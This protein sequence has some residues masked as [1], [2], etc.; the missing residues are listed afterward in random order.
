MRTKTID[1][2]NKEL[3]VFKAV[4]AGKTYTQIKEEFE[5]SSDFITAVKTKYNLKSA[6]KQGRKIKRDFSLNEEFDV[7]NPHTQE[8]L[9]KIMSSVALMKNK[10]EFVNSQ[11]SDLSILADAINP[12]S[13]KSK[14]EVI[15]EVS[16]IY[17]KMNKYVIGE[18][19]VK[20]LKLSNNTSEIGFHS[21]NFSKF[22]NK[23][24]EEV[25][26]QF[27][28]SFQK[29]IKLQVNY[30]KTDTLC[31]YFGK[32]M[33]DGSKVRES[34]SYK[35]Q[36]IMEDIINF[37]N[38][39]NEQI[40]LLNKF[41]KK[42]EVVVT[43]NDLL[44]DVNT[45]NDFIFD[46]NYMFAQFIQN[47][48]VILVENSVKEVLTPSGTAVATDWDEVEEK[49]LFISNKEALLLSKDS[50]D[51]A[52]NLNKLLKGRVKNI[53]NFGSVERKSPKFGYVQKTFSSW[54]LNKMVFTSDGKTA[55]LNS[56][57]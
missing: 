19:F 24:K 45:Y 32:N 56:I 54:I 18:T 5:C 35:T 40:A 49:Q 39:I 44:D 41:Y 17:K 33:F 50:V 12:S 51:I 15:D 7:T 23:N 47:A 29:L 55:F 16:S 3:L 10:T 34:N 22:L 28:I 1:S 2:V 30:L 57:D 20:R 11:S 53:V 8:T 26:N 21:L 52:K 27:R 31:I 14:D 42:I 25:L 13:C 36:T 43:Y 6:N 9:E 38:V 46:N 48:K 4:E 37:A